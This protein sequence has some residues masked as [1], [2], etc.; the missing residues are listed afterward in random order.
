[1]CTPSGL[2]FNKGVRAQKHGRAP[3]D[4]AANGSISASII[5]FTSSLKSTNIDVCMHMHAPMQSVGFP[6]HQDGEATPIWPFPWPATQ[7]EFGRPPWTH[8]PM[9]KME[10]DDGVAGVS[11]RHNMKWDDVQSHHA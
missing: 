3:H 1:M 8:Q 11:Q 4:G 6:T 5:L 10:P 9:S 2:Y 7:F